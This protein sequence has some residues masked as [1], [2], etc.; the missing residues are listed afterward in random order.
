[1]TLDDPSGPLV[2]WLVAEGL[3]GPATVMGRRGLSGLKSAGLGSVSPEVVSAYHRP[4][5]VV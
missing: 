3:D 2:L 4:V 5:I 1:M